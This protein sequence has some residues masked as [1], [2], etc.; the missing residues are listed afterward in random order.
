V[1]PEQLLALARVARISKAHLHSLR[2]VWVAGGLLT[3]TLLEAAAVYVCRDIIC[4]YGASESGVMADASLQDVLHDPGFAGHVLPGVDVG[5]F[6]DRGNTCG[7]GEAGL[8]KVRHAG[9]DNWIE[10]GDIG[11][12]KTGGRLYVLGRASEAGIGYLQ[13]G[14]VSP[15]HEAEHLLRLE[16]DVADAAAVLIEDTSPSQIWIGMV[17]GKGA[18]AGKLSALLHTRGIDHTVRL[19]DLKSIPRGANGKVNRAQLKAVMIAETGR[20]ASA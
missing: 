9:D 16:W 17:D 15:V 20:R 6:D 8:I 14:Q 13:G 1:S 18:D 19:F 2:T 10:L 7:H 5:I 4:R 12:L 3:R 11:R